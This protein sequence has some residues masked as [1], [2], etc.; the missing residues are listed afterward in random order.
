M[1]IVLIIVLVLLVLL[2]VGGVVAILLFLNKKK[3][4]PVAPVATGPSNLELQMQTMISQIGE[5][6][7]DVEKHKEE[8]I[9]ISDRIENNSKI[10]N[11]MNKFS[12][13]IKANLDTLHKHTIEIPQAAK[14]IASITKLYASSKNRG[15]IGELQLEMI[16]KSIFGDNSDL[17]KVQAS[18]EGGIIDALIKNGEKEIYIDAKFNRDNWEKAINGDEEA[19]KNFKQ[20]VKNMIDDLTKYKHEVLMFLPSEGLY[21]DIMNWYPE[22]FEY[23][24][25]NNIILV[26]PSTLWYTIKIADD[27]RRK[28]DIEKNIEKKINLY[29]DFIKDRFITWSKDYNDFVRGWEI[30]TGKIKKLNNSTR[31]VLNDAKKLEEQKENKKILEQAI[32]ESSNVNEELKAIEKINS[33]EEDAN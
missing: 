32:E 11:D 28:Q 19:K 12:A 6:R 21:G 22:L 24:M 3:N 13:E 14:D 2:I 8:A 23:G 10:T 25:K 5:I 4:T 26:S 17:F 30:Q 33:S 1:N 18:V 20:D 29:N 31:Y 7:K 9:K 16:L 27:F 15:N